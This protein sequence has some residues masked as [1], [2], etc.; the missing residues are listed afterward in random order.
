MLGDSGVGK[1]SLLIM[2]RDGVYMPCYYV[3]TVGIDFMVSDF[4]ENRKAKKKKTAEK[5]ISKELNVN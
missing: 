5:K 1:T 3:T 2:F 4:E